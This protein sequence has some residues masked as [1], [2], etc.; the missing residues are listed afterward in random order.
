MLDACAL[1]LCFKHVDLHLEVGNLCLVF[2]LIPDYFVFKYSEIFVYFIQIV[3][4]YLEWVVTNILFA[5]LLTFADFFGWEVSVEVLQVVLWFRGWMTN[6][7]KTIWVKCFVHI[8][9]IY[10]NWPGWSPQIA[11]WFLSLNRSLDCTLR[12]L[13]LNLNKFHLLVFDNL[14]LFL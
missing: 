7:G 12:V 14:F 1:N 4:F 10:G 9:S 6:W 13:L 11:I 2:V 3:D 8:F 5:L